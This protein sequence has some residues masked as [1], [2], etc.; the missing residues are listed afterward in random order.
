MVLD[1]GCGTGI[2]SESLAPKVKQVI[3]VD[4][5]PKMVDAYNA[6]AAAKGISNM[7]AMCVDMTGERR[8]GHMY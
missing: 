6:K 8:S 7:S 4:M 1:F 2:L 5:S 3:G